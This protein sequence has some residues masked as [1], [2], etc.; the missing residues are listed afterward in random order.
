MVGKG[1][2]GQATENGATIEEFVTRHSALLRVT[3]NDHQGTRI[4]PPHGGEITPAITSEPPTSDQHVDF[5]LAQFTR[6]PKSGSWPQAWP[7]SGADLQP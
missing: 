1:A 3:A 6:D 4:E 7:M 2:D 5:G